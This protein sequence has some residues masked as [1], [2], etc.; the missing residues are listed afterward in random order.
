MN[1][2]E[3]TGDIVENVLEIGCKTDGVLRIQPDQWTLATEVEVC[4]Q[5]LLLASFHVQILSKLTVVVLMRLNPI[6]SCI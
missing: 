6:D 5:V 1:A 4:T 3:L 2:S